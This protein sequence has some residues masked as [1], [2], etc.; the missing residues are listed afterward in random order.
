MDVL[1]T[2]EGKWLLW[3]E[4]GR[5]LTR[6]PVDAKAMIGCGFSITPPEGVE[7]V[8]PAAPPTTVQAPKPP[9]SPGASSVAS[10]GQPVE[11]PSGRTGKGKK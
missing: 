4:D 10:P 7:P 8:I 1:R 6:W 2:P 5:Q 9:S 3:D 11:I